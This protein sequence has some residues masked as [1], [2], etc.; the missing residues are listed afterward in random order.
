MPVKF[1]IDTG[2]NVSVMPESMFS[3]LKQVFLI[4][5][6]KIL[7]GPG[8]HALNVK[9]KFSASLQYGNQNIQEEI[10]IISGSKNALLGPGH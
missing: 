5:S 7:H 10:Y 3:K 4:P 2:A 1:K 8:S 6:T 9:G